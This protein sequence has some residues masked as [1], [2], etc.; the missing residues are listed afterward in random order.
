MGTANRTIFIL[1][2]IASIVSLQSHSLRG[3]GL[4]GIADE[5]V[6]GTA[7]LADDVPLKT[8]DEL[9]LDLAKSRAAREAVDAEILMAKGTRQAVNAA[10][11]S[12]EILRV[13]R[14][15]TADL[16]PNVI[17]RIEALDDGARDMA[18]VLV[19]G[20]N[21][22]N[23]TVPDIAAR[24][25]L[26][27]E[28]GSETV[29]AVGLFGPDAARAAIRLDEAIKGGTIVVRDGQRAVSVADFGRAMTRYSDASW[30][31]WKQYI[32]PHW[33]L[34]AASGALAVYLS[35]PEYFQ[36][37]T[38]QLTEGGFKHLTEMVGEVSA[39]SIRGVGQ[40]SGHALGKIADA[41]W[42]TYFSSRQGFF[43]AVGTVVFLACV[44]LFFRRIRNW[45]FWPFRWLNQVPSDSSRNDSISSS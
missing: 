44:S 43:A 38:G 25:R 18:V 21:E 12:S 13:L 34:W 7:R 39:A 26:V 32:Q 40:G 37:A 23:K 45:V 15:A 6:R 10:D 2:V 9:I 11:R 19:R 42:D 29:A 35:D 3:Q 36:D 14:A 8:V 20:G 4:R 16:D 27:R 5:L 30:N 22:L 24:G 28:G 31:F 17:R 33:K 1:A 41:T